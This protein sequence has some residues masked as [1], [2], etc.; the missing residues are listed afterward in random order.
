[1]E[2]KARKA[3]GQP[4]STANPGLTKDWPN[5]GLKAAWAVP[6]LGAKALWLQSQRSGN[7]IDLKL[8]H[9][10]GA[11]YYARY[12]T[13][14]FPNPHKLSHNGDTKINS[15]SHYSQLKSHFVRVDL[16]EPII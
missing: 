6:Q 16:L 15:T 4:G 11:K 13:C 12:L 14:V 2:V 1:M 10:F 8:L 9:N 7:R 3:V 5:P